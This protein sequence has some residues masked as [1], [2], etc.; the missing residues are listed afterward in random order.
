LPVWL[1]ILQAFALLAISAV[2]ACLA[3]QQVRIADIKL[4][5]DLFERRY[6]VF[7]ATRRMLANVCAKGDLSDD[8]LR[9][10]TIETGDV[11][12]LFNDDLAKYFDE[13]MKGHLVGL[14]A[15]NRAFESA[16]AETEQRMRA[17]NESG[18][19][20]L[21]LGDQLI[22]L[23]DRF[24]PFLRLDKRQREAGFWQVMVTWFRRRVLRRTAS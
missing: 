10:F 24:K 13:E 16:P 6:R 22:A 1:Q 23:P 9:L 3:W 2:G 18:T 14:M 5:H 15:W 8:E 4:Q 20:M 12:F 11:I 19:H 21:W 7:N 17:V